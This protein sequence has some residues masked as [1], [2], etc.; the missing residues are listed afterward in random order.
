MKKLPLISFI[1]A[2]PLISL[3]GQGLN[4]PAKHWGLSF[5]NSTRFDGLRF[6]IID[7]DIEKINGINF[8]VW[9]AKDDSRQ[10]GTVNGISI[11]IPA[12]IGTNY[13]NGINIGI[14]GAGARQDMNGINLG[15][16]GVGAGN[17]LKG[18]NLGGLGAGAGNDVKG[19]TFGI[20]GAGAG[21]DMMGINIGGLGVGAGGNVSGLNFGGLAVGS[22]G[23]VKGFSMSLLAV[24]S[25]EEVAGISLAGL[26]VGGPKVSG[27]QAAL[28]IGGEAVQGISIAPAYFRIEGFD[29]YM[30][31]FSVSAFNHIEG[32]VFGICI[33]IFNWAFSVRGFQLGILNHVKSNPKGLRWLPIFNTSFGS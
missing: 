3:F 12:A 15:G 26:A 5:G 18:I 2:L 9:G 21:N 20:L 4:I 33:G 19:I 24:G 23:S 14:F 29:G 27:I 28:V 30:K 16:L 10:T 7:K 22:G 25:G 8:N 31:G 6:N 32:D 13:R 17:N 1:L 11:G